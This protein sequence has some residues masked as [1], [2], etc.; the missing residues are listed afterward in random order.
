MQSV[1]TQT[2]LPEYIWIVCD[3]SQKNEVDARIMTLDR[4]RVKV[5]ARDNVNDIS[6]QWLQTV[7]HVSTEFVWIIDQDIAPGK[8][9]LENLLK[10]SFTKQ[11]RSL[12]LGTE[13]VIL[14]VESADKIECMPAS[15]N[16]GS[17]QMRS[18][19]VDMVNDSWLLRRSW[20]PFVLDE[21]NIGNTTTALDEFTGLFISRALYING[22]ISSIA[23][24]TDPIERAYWGDVRLQ[25]TKKSATCNNLETFLSDK[26][27]DTYN[28]LSYR[29]NGHKTTATTPVLFYVDS[30]GN[31]ENLATLLCKFED[32]QEVD[33]HVAISGSIKGLSDQQ[34][35]SSLL[36][37]CGKPS[38]DLIVHDISMLHT[39]PDWNLMNGLFHR[40]VY[41]M[42][43][44]QPRILIHTVDQENPLFLSIKSAGEIADVTNIHLPTQDISHALWIAEL[45]I[46][47]LSSK[48]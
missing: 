35:K 14:D 9:Y 41:I 4:R 11:Y 32:K 7:A 27:S 42:T 26:Q 5:M 8:R 1:L 37:L 20:I 2:A 34:V 24:P 22:G 46:D 36:N 43:V 18:K 33:L 10:L 3:T 48:L 38:V 30:I 25:K 21:I 16:S 39:A 13:A 23:L 29:N 6:H 12:L 40:L 47:T 28:T 31:L 45:P 19:V 17:Q 15:I 44:I